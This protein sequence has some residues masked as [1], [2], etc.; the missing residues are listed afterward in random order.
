MTNIIQ[1]VIVLALLMAIVVPFGMYMAAVYMGRRT[2]LDPV[3]NPVDNVIYRVSGV[4]REGM[5]WPAY[6]KAMLLTNLV[7]FFIIFIVLELQ[8][9]LPLNPDGEGPINPFLAFNSAAS[10]IT[11]TDWQNY[12]GESTKGAG[13]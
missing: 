2:W 3:L 7:M 1:M 13:G 8:P 11:N 12:G 5:R 10:F 6:V 4:N 9:L